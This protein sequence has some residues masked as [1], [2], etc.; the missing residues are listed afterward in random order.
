M[1]VNLYRFNFD[2]CVD[3]RMIEIPLSLRILTLFLLCSLPCPRLFSRVKVDDVYNVTLSPH[4]VETRSQ[5]KRVT[6]S[7]AV[8]LGAVCND[9]SPG[10]FYIS[11]SIPNYNKWIIF[12]ESGNGCSSIKKCNERYETDP[13]LMTSR[14]YPLHINGT[15]ILS[16]D[17]NTNPDYWYY[18]FVV[19][20]YCTS[21]LWIGNSTWD[22]VRTVEKF[23]FNSTDTGNQFVFRGSALFRAAA[24]ELIEHEGLAAADDVSVGVS[25]NC[26]HI[27]FH[28]YL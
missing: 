22:S 23:Q 5:F 14:L 15:D 10:I 6:I 27:V 20:P 21:D 25:V 2:D 3:R 18:N 9:R 24:K 12:L 19:I 1:Y 26:H 4:R 16:S 7:N 13:H 11:K 17:S 28:V 8:V